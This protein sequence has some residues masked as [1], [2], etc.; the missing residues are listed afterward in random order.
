MGWTQYPDVQYTY[1]QEKAEI[2]RLCA[3]WTPVQTSKVGS[4]WYVAAQRDDV[5]TAFVFLTNT[6]G[7]W[8][9]KDIGEECQPYEAKA[10]ASL[11]RKLTPTTSEGALKWR[12]NCLDH[13]A[14][15]KFKKG[16]RIR[17]ASPANF[18]THKITEFVV[19][20]YF[21][22]GKWKRCFWA[23]EIGNCRLGSYSLAGATLCES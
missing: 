7:G 20:E 12:Q 2:G 23:V 16:D 15:P 10:P 22:R 9:Y 17:L 3:P 11:I 21:T 18:G 13:A 14:R 1:A 5:I 8:S 6:K 19:S 4:T